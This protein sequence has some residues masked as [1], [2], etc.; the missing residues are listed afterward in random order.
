[1]PARL[2]I[3]IFLASRKQ[4]E[5]DTMSPWRE[6]PRSKLPAEGK[7]P[8]LVEL[9]N[10]KGGAQEITACKRENGPRWLL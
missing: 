6:I 7:Y 9:Q 2:T 10:M 5:E 1:L 8:K 3:S 4:A